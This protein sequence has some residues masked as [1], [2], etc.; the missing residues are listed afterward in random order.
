MKNTGATTVDVMRTLVF[1]VIFGAIALYLFGSLNQMQ[2]GV[3]GLWIASLAWLSS[4]LL[5][6]LLVFGLGS[7]GW[8][9]RVVVVA[10]VLA[11]IVSI[12]WIKEY[13][14]VQQYLGSNHVV[15]GATNFVV[16]QVNPW[17]PLASLLVS[18]I[19]TFTSVLVSV[20]AIKSQNRISAV[21]VGAINEEKD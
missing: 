16:Q 6:W 12:E 3:D 7:L 10:S 19:G 15:G 17:V 21:K 11:F 1:F 9:W 20:S 18:V 2:L 8:F 4:M 14:I 13:R 5:S